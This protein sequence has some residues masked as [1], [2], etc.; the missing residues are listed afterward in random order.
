MLMYNEIAQTDMLWEGHWKDLNDDLEQRLQC[1]HRDDDLYLSIK[2]RRSLGFYE[3]QVI[4]NRN[5]HSLTDFPL[6]LLPSFNFAQHLTNWLIREQLDCDIDKEAATLNLLL[7]T[8]NSYQ[9]EVFQ[10]IITAGDSN[11]GGSGNGGIGTT[12]V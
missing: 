3:L 12:H 11:E 9:L 2:R 4:L 6:M 5:G 7:P 1:K 10:N 8:L